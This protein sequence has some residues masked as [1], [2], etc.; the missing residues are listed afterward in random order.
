MAASRFVDVP[1]RE[2]K[3]R[4]RR[5]AELEASNAAAVAMPT[6]APGIK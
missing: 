3:Y 2:G 6:E 1:A 4:L 5:A